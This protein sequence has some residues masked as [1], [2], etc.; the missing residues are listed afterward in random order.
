[1]DT[2]FEFGVMSRLHLVLS[3]LSN[4]IPF[5]VPVVILLR[6]KLYALHW[7]AV[8]QYYVCYVVTCFAGGTND[9]IEALDLLKWSIFDF[10]K[11]LSQPVVCEL[12]QSTHGK[13]DDF[14]ITYSHHL[15]P[16]V[17]LDVILDI[18]Q[19]SPFLNAPMDICRCSIL[20][21]QLLR[22]LSKFLI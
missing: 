21:K 2:N 9:T 22:K 15:R 4:M 12:C 20:L 14:W 16:T 5:C 3:T 6:R 8:K 17:V 13:C 18:L 7:D 19:L 10:C 11:S 1:M